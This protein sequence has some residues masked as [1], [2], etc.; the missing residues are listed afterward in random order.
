MKAI[1]MAGGEGSRLR[2]LTC[3][4][5]K[6]MVP[7][8]DRP[9][10]AYALDL[11]KK[12]GIREVGV[13]MQYLPERITEFFG[14]GAEFGVHLNYFTEETPLGTAGSVKLA[15]KFLDETFV[16]LS[17]DGLTDCDLTQAAEFHRSHGALATMVLK[18]VDNPLEYGVVVA[19]ADGKVNRFLE[20]PGW[21]EVCSD[22][23]NTGIYILEPEALKYIPAGK[24]HDFGRELF[25]ALV[26][27]GQKIFGYVM[28]GYWC[29]IGDIAAYLKAHMD[30]LDGRA[31]VDSPAR[32][33]AVSKSAN[34]QVD[35][36]AILEGPC[37][38]GEGVR[39]LEGAR[40]GAYS[41]LGAGCVVEKNASVKRGVIW[42]GARIGEG[43]QLRSAV[44]QT[45]ATV[46]PRASVFEEGALGDHSE[47][48]EGCVLMPGVR[49]WPHKEVACGAKVDQNLVWGARSAELFAPESPAQAVRLSQAFAASMKPG[50]VVIGRDNSLTAMAQARAASAGLIAQGA[51]VIELGPSTLPQVSQAVRSLDAG[52]AMYVAAE[53]L[54]LL[55]EGGTTPT[56]AQMR[57]LS[58]TLAR[59][60][61][62]RPFSARMFAPVMAGGGE[63]GYLAALTKG[64][65]A[66]GMRVQLYAP[67]EPLLTTAERA[68]LR[69]GCQVR[70]EWEQELMDPEPGEVGLMLDETGETVRFYGDG[71]LIGEAENQQIL[72]WT[73]LSMG[74]KR[75]PM[76]PGMTRSVIDLAARRGAVVE[77]V[78]S[79][80]AQWMRALLSE[81]ERLLKLYFDGVYAAVRALH[82][83]KKEGLTV[84]GVIRSMPSVF[85]SDRV[86]TVELKDRGAL[87]RRLAESVPGASL[88]DGVSFEDERGWAWV[89]APGEKK[90]CRV[91]AEAA[92][93]EFAKELCDFCSGSLEKLIKD[94]QP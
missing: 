80:R 13:T 76:P 37:F 86:V 68:L 44:I 62:A 20:K 67:G 52:G 9:V 3:A 94:S 16:I 88:S 65:D 19:D 61:Y 10:M 2:P 15:E 79:D 49:I 77:R 22:T 35:R 83:M 69:A 5:P 89:S 18:K 14:D 72:C 34:A 24:P 21:G 48:G 46:G 4:C 54:T 38:I 8:M 7:L 78:P 28:R 90:E 6:P 42:R 91:L 32:P 73:A 85:R 40:I 81:D 36:G 60:D 11:L 63:R 30:L 33:G 74:V 12:H 84:S 29:D 87:L 57:S 25:P 41:V 71:G 55:T 51:Q 45:G 53:R 39:V 59:E 26:E 82:A 47:L 58:G 23:V 56:S 92:S 31:A 93:A 43:A 50:S 64:A 1:I 27:K 75:I 66:E 17:G 70:A